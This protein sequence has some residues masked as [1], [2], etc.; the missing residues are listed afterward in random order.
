MVK[1]LVVDDSAVAREMITTILNTDSEIEVIGKA[2]NGKEAID[3]LDSNPERPDIITCDLQMPIMNG[4]DTIEHIMAYNPIPILIVTVLNKDDNFMK[5][6]KLGA[7]DI[8]QKP[9]PNSWEDIPK[10]GIELIEKVKLLSRVNVVVHLDGKKK[11]V[12]KEKQKKTDIIEKKLFQPDWVVGIASSTG[13]PTTLLRLFKM[14]PK[15]FP[16]PILVVQ[17]M[18]EG[19]FIKGLIEWFRNSIKL[20]IEQ[21]KDGGVLKNGTIYISPIDVH[22]KLKGRTIILDDSPPVKNQKPSADILFNSL[23]E[24]HKKSSIG[25]VLTGI[26]DDGSDGI[27]KIKENRGLTIAQDEDTSTVFGMP[28]AAINTGC[29]DRVL[30]L[31]DIGHFLIEFLIDESNNSNS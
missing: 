22:L 27:R 21:A 25:I 26:G 14:L 13:G 29:V 5:A 20:P 17:H 6:L 11:A 19:F 23:A 1:V 12:K 18:S 16:A 9:A 10:I 4:F 28:K 3:F 8:I 2:I 24:Y 30:P 31:E 7:L 15:S